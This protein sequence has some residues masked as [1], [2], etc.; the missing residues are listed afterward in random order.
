[1]RRAM[2]GA[3]ALLFTVGCRTPSTPVQ[4]QGDPLSI[5]WVAGEWAGSYWG[6]GRGGSLTFT[7]RSGTDSLYGDVTMVDRA[8]QSMRAADPL[9]VH[10]V[11]V[12]SPQQLRIDFVAIHADSIRGMLEPYVSPECDCTVGTTFVGAVR[13]NTIKGTFET[14]SGGRPLAQGQWEMT[15]VGDAPR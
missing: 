7:L 15:R 1:M 10:S 9:D 4:L 5:R 11:H 13:G 2:L 14:R 6:A 8:G 12:R 3:L